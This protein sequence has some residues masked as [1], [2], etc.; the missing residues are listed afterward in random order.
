MAPSSLAK[1]AAL[2]AVLDASWAAGAKAAAEPIRA[3]KAVVFIMESVCIKIDG[4]TKS[5]NTVVES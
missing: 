4:M 3:R 2:R 1:G 5:R